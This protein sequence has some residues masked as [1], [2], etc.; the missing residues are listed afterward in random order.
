[1]RS[2]E[3]ADWLENNVCRQIKHI[4]TV[5]RAEDAVKLENEGTSGGN[6]VFLTVGSTVFE[7]EVGVE[8]NVG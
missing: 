3:P 1:M 5:W 7:V 2:T 6:G 8:V 4:S